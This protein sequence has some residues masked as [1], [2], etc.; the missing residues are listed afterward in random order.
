MVRTRKDG[1]LTIVVVLLATFI[2]IVLLGGVSGGMMDGGMM[3]GMI[4]FGWLLMVLP[5]LLIIF[6]VSSLLDRNA[7]P[8][9]RSPQYG[10]YGTETPMQILERRYASGDISREDFFKMKREIYNR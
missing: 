2:G 6:L 8:S 3:G 10:H 9:E 1:W 7:T 4:V 5:I